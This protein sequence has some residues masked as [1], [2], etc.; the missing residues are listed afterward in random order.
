ME[1]NVNEKDSTTL[2][3]SRSEEGEA[4]I[5]GEN[6]DNETSVLEEAGETASQV[7]QVRQTTI[8][9]PYIHKKL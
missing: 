1:F 3:N 8:I 9:R 4:E 2:S 5:P 7:F 6:D